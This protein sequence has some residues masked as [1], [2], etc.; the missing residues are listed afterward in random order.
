M[1]R[2]ISNTSQVRSNEIDVTA[3]GAEF[4]F[5]VNGVQLITDAFLAA[6]NAVA[7][8]G[9]DQFPPSF[10][11]VCFDAVKTDNDQDTIVACE[12]RMRVGADPFATTP[13]PITLRQRADFDSANVTVTVL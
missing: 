5:P 6:A 13:I 11:G 7:T 8:I 1:A 2:R 9:R 4:D 10:I 12:V 3:T